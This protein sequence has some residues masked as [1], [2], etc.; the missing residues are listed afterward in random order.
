ME[1]GSSCMQQ[2][3]GMLTR[4]ENNLQESVGQILLRKNHIA[5]EGAKTVA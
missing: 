4:N 5:D 1:I 3:R 2:L